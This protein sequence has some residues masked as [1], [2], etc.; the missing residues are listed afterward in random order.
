MTTQT[1]PRRRWQN[2][3]IAHETTPSTSAFGPIRIDDSTMKPDPVYLQGG[4]TVM[5]QGA[6]IERT[7]F[8]C[9]WGARFEVTCDRVCTY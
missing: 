1:I 2:L 3:E 9:S 6:D 4:D 7:C 8:L 5:H